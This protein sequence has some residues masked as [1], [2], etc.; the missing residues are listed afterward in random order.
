VTIFGL[1][2]IDFTIIIAYVAFVLWL[3]ERARRRMKTSE[4]F[5]IAGRRIGKVY[6]F[7]LNLGTSTSPDQAVVV[8]REIYRQGIGGMWIQYLVL[9]LTPFYWFTTFWFRRVRLVTIGDYFEERFRSRFLG[10]AFAAFSLVMAV[11]GIGVGYMV[12]AKT[13]MALT[14][15]PETRCTVEERR[16]VELFRE[17]NGLRARHEAGAVLVPN[18]QQ[19]FEELSDRLKRGELRAF[20]SY[21][22]PAVIYAIYAVVVALYTIMGGFI[23]AVITDVIQGILI[24]IFSLL[25]IPVGLARIGGFSALHAAVPGH[26]FNLFGSTAMG[27]YAWYTIAAM[28]LANLVS[29][30]A[31]AP[32]MA[33]AGS[34]KDEMSA[35]IG[36]IGG[37]YFK[38]FIMIFWALAGLLAIALY[39]NQ[40][41][42]PDLIW[43]YM[44]RD[45]LFP[46][47]IGLMLAGVLAGK[48]S[49]LAATCV[50]N[51]ALVI[52]NLY[53]PIRP[54]RGD[55]HYINAGRIMIVVTIV[56]GAATALY[57]D[58]LLE[59]FKYFISIP[60]IFGAAIWLG[61]VWRRLTKR[62]VILQV[63]VCFAI[64]A[65]IPNVFLNLE[66]ARANPRL[67]IET[68][69]RTVTMPAVAMAEDVAAGRAAALGQ[70]IAKTQVQ[71]PSAVFFEQVARRD[72]AD[73]RSAKI[74]MGRF[75]AEIW[76]LSWLGV[77]FTRFSKAQLVAV[78]FY[79]D[80]LFPFFLLFL[81]SFF[82]RPVAKED[83][84]KFFVRLRTPVQAT[85]EADRQA[86]A[87]AGGRFETFEKDKIWPGSNWEIYKPGWRDVLGFGGSWA[88]VGV[89][90]FLLWFMIN[91]R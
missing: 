50:A 28:A 89:I 54:D 2:W 80:A 67:T 76:V 14:P 33:T 42:D 6:Q 40:L 53:R 91:L 74:G 9:F 12:A 31:S 24:I 34:A 13:M 68:Q 25:L 69:A 60:A 57:I 21:T 61:F 58:N 44:T 23:A 3:G 41:H 47:A 75:H 39:S 22:N 20:I 36:M 35:R 10:A 88:L 84:D 19:R 52:Q 83:L 17:Y 72:P 85:P 62:A 29:I 51:S 78:R 32:G 43:G 82:S 65:V 55:R 49:S 81:F 1:H 64:Y 73:P 90:I 66:W 18:E 46:G 87:D 63:F 71:E 8:S 15:K 26:M 5:F 70:T 79:F 77:D 86:L 45:L 27:E 7:F 38:R 4:D 11:I 30:I 59:L 37:M 56:V 48:M 16:S